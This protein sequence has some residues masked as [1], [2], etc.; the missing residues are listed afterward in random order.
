MECPKPLATFVRPNGGIPRGRDRL[1]LTGSIACHFI[2]VNN[3]VIVDPVERRVGQTP[4]REFA[5][6]LHLA[7]H[8]VEFGRFH[9]TFSAHSEAVWEDVAVEGTYARAIGY[10][11]FQ[12]R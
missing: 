7:H 3:G 2:H 5:I 6:G 8:L 4:F 10:G 12:S 1:A 11:I 9:D